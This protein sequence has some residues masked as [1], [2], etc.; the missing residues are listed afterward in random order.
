MPIIGVAVTADTAAAVVATTGTAAVAAI[1]VEYTVQLGIDFFGWI[2]ALIGA[3]I[4][5]YHI[6]FGRA[7]F[8]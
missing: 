8:K 2:N 1:I 7:E 6:L 5:L 3:G 4:L